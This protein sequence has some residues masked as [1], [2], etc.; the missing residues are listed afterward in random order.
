MGAPD[1]TGPFKIGDLIRD[2]YEVRGLLGA[3]GHAFVYECLDRYMDAI[4]AV[5]VIA[6][7]PGRGKELLNRAHAEAKL[8]FRLNHPNV[9]RVMNARPVGDSMVCIVMEKLAGL[10]LRQF[11]QLHSRLT[12]TEAL[13]I[14]RQIAE[15]V[16][17][18]H[19]LDVIHRD[20]KPENV[21]LLPPNNHVKV[22][23]FGIAKFMGQGFET[24]N[25]ARIH[26]TP[27]YM[28]PEHLQNTSI[29]V[30]SDIYELGTL[31][32]EL[33]TGKIPCLVD[34]ENPDFNQLA[35][36]QISKVTP[37][38]TRLIRNVG[39]QTEYLVQRSTAKE[40][41]QR[42]A[43]ME[44]V[45][46]AV[47]V[48]LAEQRTLY[49]LEWDSQRFVDDDV[50]RQVQ[51][52]A[53][54]AAQDDDYT[55]QDSKSATAADTRNVG[56]DV[57]NSTGSVE[58]ENLKPDTESTPAPHSRRPVMAPTIEHARAEPASTGTTGHH[59]R[60]APS[61]DS[62]EPATTNSATAA[63]LIPTQNS[64]DFPIDVKGVASQTTPRRRIPRS[65]FVAPVLLGLVIAVA[66]SWQDIQRFQAR[67]L[68]ASDDGGGL[69]SSLVTIQRSAAAPVA[70]S[71][72]IG[73]QIPVPSTS[74]AAPMPKPTVTVTSSGAA[75]KS[76]RRTRVV[77][78]SI[79]PSAH[80]DRR[81]QK[82]AD[83]ASSAHP[84]GQDR[85][86]SSHLPAVAP[87]DAKP[88][89]RKASEQ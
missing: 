35:Y 15:G 16:R 17:A 7:L 6:I 88:K 2:E 31:A 33:M 84:V 59:D 22:L 26:G 61:P 25:K 9:V 38:L 72:P 45:M 47:D 51:S 5:K 32:F 27:L 56:A 14:V 20:I 63:N 39:P 53:D 44:E 34:L 52:V 46:T 70:H 65:V 79:G 69:A 36:V 80:V 62:A 21:F 74:V 50:I 67:R 60:I 4:V 75:A 12:V 43:S 40:P 71:V 10:S 11:L 77:A 48:A 76:E 19:Q 55:A 49:P 66:V 23:D 30:R 73:H 64:Q 54:T 85:V 89:S 29:T 18:A 3:G 87:T 24:T 68:G 13:V 58:G 78:S 28:S 1:F 41:A 83:R 81:G 86:L 42:F 82:P 8:L 37:P 57:G